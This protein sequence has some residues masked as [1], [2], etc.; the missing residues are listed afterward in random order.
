MPPKRTRRKRDEEEEVEE[1]EP[2]TQKQKLDDSDG[3]ST[4]GAAAPTDAPAA[5]TDASLDEMDEDESEF[6][7]AVAPKEP[8]MSAAFKDIKSRMSEAKSVERQD[9]MGKREASAAYV[10]QQADA[11]TRQQEYFKQAEKCPPQYQKLAKILALSTMVLGI[12]T[13]LRWMYSTTGFVASSP[14]MQKTVGIIESTAN[15]ATATGSAAATAARATGSAAASAAS[16]T[17]SALSTVGRVSGVTGAARAVGSAV[18]SSCSAAVTGVKDAIVNITPQVASV[19][20]DFLYHA[21]PPLAVAYAVQNP[22]VVQRIRQ[23]I[24]R[25]TTLRSSERREADI[26]ELT[27]QLEQM[28]VGEKQGSDKGTMASLKSSAAA[29]ASTVSSSL[30]EAKD[31]LKGNTL[32]TYNTLFLLWCRALQQADESVIQKLLDPLGMGKLGDISGMEGG[33][34]RRHRKNKHGKKTR[35]HHKK[36]HKKLHKKAHKSHKKAKQVT[37]KSKQHNKRKTQKSRR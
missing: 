34:S 25:L 4:D 37:R 17:G 26:S 20:S 21:G 11:R 16:A 36:S 14:A 5:P 1:T 6:K 15:A 35:K 29:A 28:K 9:P 8:T 2:T 22:E 27:F 23:R 31:V 13:T 12:C 24:D 10:K 33:K 32:E 3:A 7:D 18:A 30:M 19:I